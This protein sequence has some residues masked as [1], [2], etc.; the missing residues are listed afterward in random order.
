MT[1]TEIRYAAPADDARRAHRAALAALRAGVTRSA[2]LWRSSGDPHAPVP[3]LDWTVAETAAHVV[4]DL[5]EFTH[6][7]GEGGGPAVGTGSP[8]RRGAEVNARH[9]QTVPERDM[10]LLA[11]MLE[12]R[13]EQYLATVARTDENAQIPTAN[14]LVLIPS[15]M[16]SLLLG[17]QVMHGQDI[18]LASAARWCVSRA[19]ALLVIPGVLA[20]TPEYLH[21]KRSAGVTVSFELRIRGGGRYRLAVDNGSAEITAAG[22]KADCVINADPVAFLE[23]GYGRIPQWR[24][25]ISGKMFP[26]GR[27]P[28]LAAKFGTLLTRP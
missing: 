12:E 14:G 25:I 28:W 11:D 16:T 7:L 21:P 17:E 22:E 10:A 18:A 3:G 20:V 8:S 4:G 15:V 26:A 19:D 27:K 2:H 23:L 5:R 6:A 13:A 9:L 1:T 24:P